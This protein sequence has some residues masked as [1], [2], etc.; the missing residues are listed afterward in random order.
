MWKTLM[1]D[2]HLDG[3]FAR[4][5]LSIVIQAQPDGVNCPL[6]LLLHCHGS[7]QT[8]PD[9]CVPSMLRPLYIDM[10]VTFG[11]MMSNHH[12]YM[13]YLTSDRYHFVNNLYRM[14]PLPDLN[15][16]NP[17]LRRSV[18]LSTI[19]IQ[20]FPLLFS[21]FFNFLVTVRRP[22]QCN[23]K[24]EMEG[25]LVLFLVILFISFICITWLTT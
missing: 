9:S 15:M 6:R 2:V 22:I 24:I 3:G 18:S 1:C 12:M 17:L 25:F 8:R 14:W 21:Q 11:C 7:R 20:N 10:L 23:C 5:L 13:A 19:S 4:Q 16:C